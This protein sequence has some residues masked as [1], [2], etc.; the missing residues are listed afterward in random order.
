MGSPDDRRRAERVPVNAQFEAA[1]STLTY[2]RDLSERG[3]FLQTT[4]RMPIGA[5]L[6]LRFTVVL[7]DP[8]LIEGQGRVVRHQASPPGMGIEFTDLDPTMILRIHDAVAHERPRDSGPPLDLGGSDDSDTASTIPAPGRSVAFR[9]NDL[10]LAVVGGRV[11]PDEDVDE[12]SQT[13]VN[14]RSVDAEIVDDD[15]LPMDDS[16]TQ[17]VATS[18]KEGEA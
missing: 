15:D 17:V 5:L 11:G 8:V 7:D 12:N 14:L 6:S 18:K 4:Q 10:E 13:L 3:V 2:V 9:A 16:A 1:E